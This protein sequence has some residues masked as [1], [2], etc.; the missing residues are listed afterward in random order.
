MADFELDKERIKGYEDEEDGGREKQSGTRKMK[1]FYIILLITVVVGL[2]LSLGLGLG[3]PKRGSNTNNEKKCKAWNGKR[4]F[5]HSRTNINWLNGECPN[6][7]GRKNCPSHMKS[8]PTILISLDGFRT[9]YLSRNV[10]PAIQKLADCG[11]RAESLRSIYP[12][13]T[14]PNHYSM[15]TGLYPESHGVIDNRMW[16]PKTKDFFA[17][18]L[19]TKN[20]P[21]WYQGRP[22]WLNAQ[23]NGKRVKTFFWPGTDVVHEG[24]LP[25]DCY[26]YDSSVPYTARIDQILEWFKDKNSPPDL[27]IAY[28]EQPDSAGHEY[29]PF[30]ENVV[31]NLTRVDNLINRLISGLIQENLEECVN[32]VLVSDHGMAETKCSKTVNLNEYLDTSNV[33]VHQGS[34]TRISGKYR[35]EGGK[36]VEHNG[37]SDEEIM[38]KMSCNYYNNTKDWYLNAMLKQDLPVRM[39]YVQ[40]P[41]IDNVVVDVENG[42]YTLSSSQC[43]IAKGGHG[44]DY[45]DENMKSIFLGYGPGFKQ[46]YV[47]EEFSNIEIYNLI[48]NLLDI[49]P[50]NNNGTEHALDHFLSSPKNVSDMIEPDFPIHT[51]LPSENEMKKRRMSSNCRCYDND[52]VDQ[53]DKELNLTESQAK[54]VINRVLP[55]GEPF[56]KSPYKRLIQRNYAIGYKESLETPL[57]VAFQVLKPINSILDNGSKVNDLKNCTRPD[58]RIRTSRCNV[59]NSMLLTKLFPPELSPNSND[60]NTDIRTNAVKMNKQFADTVWIHLIRLIEEYGEKFNLINVILGP[61]FDSNRDG[62]VDESPADVPTHFYAVLYG[63]LTDKIVSI[64]IPHKEISDCVKKYPLIDYFKKH[65]VSL[66]DLELITGLIF[67][68]KLRNVPERH[69]RFVQLH[70]LWDELEWKDSNYNCELCKNN[71]KSTKPLLLISI[72]G[73]RSDKYESLDSLAKFSQCGVR[74]KKMRSVFPSITFPNHYSQVTGLYPQ[75]HGIIDNA[76][77]DKDIG[78][79]F[80]ISSPIAKISD[81]WKGDPIW[82]TIRRDNKTAFTYFWPGSDVRIKGSYPNVYKMFNSDVPNKERV[83]NVIEWLERGEGKYERADL[84]TLYFENVDKAGHDGG[85]HSIQVKE[86]SK[87]LDKELKKIF[88]YIYR[89]RKCVNVV[90]ISDHGMADITCDNQ[91]VLKD[92]LSDYALSKMNAFYGTGSRISNTYTRGQNGSYYNIPENERIPLSKIKANLSTCLIKNL[93]NYNKE[94]API[95]FHYSQSKRIEE[96]LVFI[97]INWLIGVVKKE[98]CHLKGNH[99][100]DP[101]E[102]D[103]KAFFAGV[104]PD[105]RLNFTFDYEFENIE[106]YNLISGLL[107]VTPSPNNGTEN[108]L[109]FLLKNPPKL[110]IKNETESNYNPTEFPDLATYTLRINRTNCSICQN[111]T[112]DSS[113]LDILNDEKP[114]LIE[115][116]IKHGLPEITAFQEKPELLFQQ[117]FVT[118]YWKLISYPAMVAAHLNVSQISY[119]ENS[120]RKDTDFCPYKIDF[121]LENEKTCS[122]FK[123]QQFLFPL[124]WTSEPD[125]AKYHTNVVEMNEDFKSNTW[126]VLLKQEVEDKLINSKEDLYVILGTAFDYNYDG[127]ADNLTEI[128]STTPSHY[129]LITLKEDVNSRWHGKSWVLPHLKSFPE[130]INTSHYISDHRTRIRDVE[131]ITGMRFLTNIDYQEGLLSR[132]S[133]TSPS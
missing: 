8:S 32:I 34:F 58:V 57:F 69:K 14:F 76:M 71:D 101:T 81:W 106:L 15:V 19:P 129:F 10:T 61:V 107:N 30:S 121:R 96:L 72:D 125:E 95:R 84:I 60:N 36:V 91:V 100:W 98:L 122:S 49:K 92:Y 65:I 17:L 112:H 113:M 55:L 2:S 18:N 40:H 99:G 103:M 41:R 102:D 38:N 88:N 16:D 73:L 118:S 94:L 132:I 7:M 70:S 31:S 109:S 117:S 54:E 116:H 90:I 12:T 42:W 51:N 33:Y 75:H 108:S 74:A 115:K 128:N 50:N 87:S 77:Y 114:Q 63:N 4:V 67:F 64:V 126:S 47:G 29:G 48:C 24:K 119:K 66:K 3:L 111:F 35:R 80:Y 127:L 105:F 68:T 97:N 22:I 1:L 23:D 120:D 9:E 130:C 62:I 26:Q 28:F 123:D 21:K 53:F 37:L 59:D 39:H 45:L 124:K 46:G 79:F 13:K 83:R 56:S 104:G 25:D 6:R 11:V 89:K 5:S 78:K 27:V 85:P 82:N 43:N 20:D 44:Y 131:L 110:D 52:T 133:L 93:Q 86:E